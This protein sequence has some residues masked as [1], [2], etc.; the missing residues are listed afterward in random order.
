MAKKLYEVAGSV[1]LGSLII[2]ILVLSPGPPKY[3]KK[4][5]IMNHKGCSKQLFGSFGGPG[6]IRR[7]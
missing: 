2:Y 3:R 7:I 6:C 5:P 1:L 4:A